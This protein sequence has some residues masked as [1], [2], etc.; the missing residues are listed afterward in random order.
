MKDVKEYLTERRSENEPL[1]GEWAFMAELY[2]KR[3]WHQL[4][5]K[6]M[7]F[8]KNDYFLSNGGL[9]DLYE[10]FLSDFENKINPLSLMEI[11]MSIIREIQD[12]ERAI[13]FLNQQKEKVKAS[14]DAQ[15]LCLTAIGNLKLSEK[16]L[17]ETKEIIEEVNTLLENIQGITTVHARFYDLSSGYDKAAGSFNDY[18]RNALR[19]L[20]CIDVADLPAKEQQ[21]RAFNLALAAL[22]GSDIY[23]FGELLAHPVLDSITKTD[24]QWVVDL[25][26]AFNSGDIPRF[27]AMKST[28]T[29]QP[30]LASHELLL[31]QK[32]TLLCLMEMAFN[33]PPN[34]RSLS[35][36][37]IATDARI[38]VNEVELLVM[39]AL[40]IGLIKGSINE[41]NKIVKISWVQPRVLDR[42]QIS[43]MKDRLSEWCDK[44]KNTSY[45]VEDQVPEL[46]I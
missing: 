6:L 36:K 30:D 34:D 5:L 24:H 18:Y 46:L 1:S 31:R 9:L 32:I 3:L 25:L 29:K 7:E 14:H 35:F 8:V 19:F 11:I 38:P 13:E 33:R 42:K 40:S 16:K 12:P 45:M 37:E 15:V 21:D 39:K 41:V 2:D 10:N 26:Y 28:W 43:N 22:L 23:N 20:G 27:E 44:T 4:T 17:K